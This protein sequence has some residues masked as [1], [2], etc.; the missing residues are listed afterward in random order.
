MHHHTALYS[1]GAEQRDPYTA[2][3]IS[4]YTKIKLA[5]ISRFL[6]LNSRRAQSDCTLVHHLKYAYLDR[7]HR[8][9]SLDRL[10]VDLAPEPR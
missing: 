10:H 6:L 7:L 4:I 1:R 9:F 5:A 8:L 3:G 2:A